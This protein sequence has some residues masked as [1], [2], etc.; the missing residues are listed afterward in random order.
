L[1]G[2]Q[3]PLQLIGVGVDGVGHVGQELP[4]FRDGPGRPRREGG[5][6]GGDRVVE[7]LR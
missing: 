7:L 4:T 3:Q 2:R 5:T 6:G 1:L